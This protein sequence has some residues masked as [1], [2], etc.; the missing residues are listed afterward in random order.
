M[1]ARKGVAGHLMRRGPAC[2]SCLADR[3]PHWLPLSSVKAPDR[4]ER[5]V[6]REPRVIVSSGALAE[7]ARPVKSPRIAALRTDA[8]GQQAPQR[9]RMCRSRRWRGGSRPPDTRRQGTPGPGCRA[10]PMRFHAVPAAT[11]RPDAQRAA[12]FAAQGEARRPRRPS[13]GRRRPDC[14][15]EG[16]GALRR[17]LRVAR[18][19]RQK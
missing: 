9:A 6:R 19:A 13:P 5:A 4:D 14:G 18:A 10:I 11:A 7:A 16:S 3:T 8:G 17:E 15:P 1:G 12:H 2:R